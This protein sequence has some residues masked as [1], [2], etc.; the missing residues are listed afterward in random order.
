MTQC[1]TPLVSVVIPTLNEA[2]YLEQ[3]LLSIGELNRLVECIVVDAGSVDRTR[4]IARRW[5][6]VTLL[7]SEFPGRARQMNIGG[8]VARGD[9][10][11]FLHADCCL[12]DNA[13]DNV[14]QVLADKKCV[15]G[16]FCLGFA[17]RHWV[18][19]LCSWC[20]RVNHPWTT[21][22]DQAQFMRRDIFQVIGGFQDWPLMEDLE[23]QY[24]LRKHGHLIKIRRP[25]ISSDRRYRRHGPLL[26][27]LFNIL[28]VVLYLLG[29]SPQ[30]LARWYRPQCHGE[31]GNA[32][33]HEA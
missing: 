28:L 10:L 31:T 16:S 27:Q 4:D 8:R 3:A 15:G 22:G 7:T 25:V 2:D 24:R 14:Q 11:L 19:R 1:K 30:R 13:L 33:R 17:Q 26:H 6:N 12:P 21:Y 18:L 5:Q 23:I 32:A 29:V 9:I 20:S